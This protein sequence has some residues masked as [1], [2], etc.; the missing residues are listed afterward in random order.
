[1]STVQEVLNRKGHDVV[2][3]K[4][5]DNVL[6]AAR[7]MNERRVGS[8]TVTEGDSKVIGIFTERDV[9]CR[10]VAA[11]RDPATTLVREVMT[12]PVACCSP[13]TTQAECRAVMR[14]RRVRHLPVVKD[15]RL[16][17]IVSIGDILEVAEE[18]QQETI[19]YLYE[20]MLGTWSE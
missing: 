3:V 17:G 7:L 16:V 11:Q 9:L 18:Q 1:M 8:L 14:H 10:I 13:E 20:Y 4:A 19:R 12:A 5:S 15:D 6:T 2:T